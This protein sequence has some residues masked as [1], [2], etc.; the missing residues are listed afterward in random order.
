M[1]EDAL[2]STRNL[3]RLIIGV[4]LAVL[5]FSL[6]ISSA[7]DKIRQKNSI[8]TLI[9][10]NF[11]EYESWLDSHLDAEI[12]TR[13]L[14]A[15]EPLQ[16]FLNDSSHLIFGLDN[17]A[18][19]LQKP[20]H[21]G[22][23]LV[24]ESLLS[25]VSAA[26]LTSLA[27]LNGLSLDQDVQ[28]TVPQVE[29]LIAQLEDFLNSNGATGKRITS[30]MNSI[31]DDSPLLATFLPDTATVAFLSFELTDTSVAAATPVFQGLYEFD[32]ITIPDTSFISWVDQK[33]LLPHV[34]T[35]NNELQF[36]PDL[37]PLPKGY[38][39]EPLGKLSL[40]L[41]DEI[42]SAGPDQRTIK[43]LGTEV[44]GRLLVLAA[45][46]IL[47]ALL[48]YFKSHLSHICRMSSAHAEEMIGFSWLPLN[49]NVWQI[50][51]TSF[52]GSAHVVEIV[53]TLALL[54]IGALVVM[55]V[56]LGLFGSVHW[57]T[58]LLIGIT[59]MFAIL[60]CY[61]SLQDVRSIRNRLHSD[62]DIESTDIVSNIE[63]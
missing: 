12:R 17:I 54:P 32:L 5:V 61:M 18:D 26:N 25:S 52:T 56:R 51:R 45:P 35:T 48:Y 14:P 38:S 21:I 4:S 63:N 27:A 9:D 19:V 3:H 50:P 60:I 13:V 28:I 43:I 58:A 36:L 1:I 31:T 62:P 39:E 59:C 42:R 24:G 33:K 15:T 57:G 40:R 53:S 2:K 47:L 34:R 16:K 7:Q 30:A 11:L 29:G 49:A 23:F 20:A 22:Q 41:E 46:L 10:I 37:E 6:S 8:D 44:P 55:Y